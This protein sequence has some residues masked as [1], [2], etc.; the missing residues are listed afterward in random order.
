[1]NGAASHDRI[2]RSGAEHQQDD[3]PTRSRQGNNGHLYPQYSNTGNA[4]AIR[5][6]DRGH[7]AVNTSFRERD[8]WRTL[9]QRG[10]WNIGNLAAGA[11]ASVQLVVQVTSPLPN[12][13]SSPTAPTRSTRT[14]RH[15]EWSGGHD[16]VTS[17]PILNISKADSPDPAV[18]GT[19]NIT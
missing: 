8:R 10:D 5:R 12:A 14:R 19:D 15:R 17:D 7:R 6:R 2:V 16:D 1:V 13:R 9:R 11:S 3:A 18:A 4:N